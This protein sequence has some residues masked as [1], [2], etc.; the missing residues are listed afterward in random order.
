[1]AGTKRKTPSKSTP[2]AKRKK[3]VASDDG[4]VG[5]RVARRRRGPSFDPDA[6]Y[7]PSD[8]ESDKENQSDEDDPGYTSEG[9]VK[10]S[11]PIRP[12]K[13]KTG[14]KAR[15]EEVKQ[16]RQNGGKATATAPEPEVP[17]YVEEGR[18]HPKDIKRG[19]I[20][21]I[22][23]VEEVNANAIRRNMDFKQESGTEVLKTKKLDRELYLKFR[24]FLIIGVFPKHFVAL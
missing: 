18:L 3:S 17:D 12:L 9:K 10:P 15:K 7:V 2:T 19:N 20:I 4:S 8:D 5:S 14:A 24:K 23:H 21:S 22:Y 11:R 16:T 6:E 13:K 1:M